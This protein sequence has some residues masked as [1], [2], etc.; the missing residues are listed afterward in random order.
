LENK[1]LSNIPEDVGKPGGKTFEPPAIS[2]D[3]RLDVIIEAW[4]GL[5]EAVR[6]GITAI[7]LASSSLT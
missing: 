4:G 1:A 5:P 7:V 2:S 3:G 6:A